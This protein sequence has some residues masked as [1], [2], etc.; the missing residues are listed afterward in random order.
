MYRGDRQNRRG[1]TLVEL[2][3][4]IAIIGMLVSLLLPAVQAA[5]EAARR[6]ECANNLKQIGLALQAYHDARRGF[7]PGWLWAPPADQSGG[8]SWAWS[9]FILP[10]LERNSLY[11][12]LRVDDG[13]ALVP[14]PGDP[15]DTLLPMFVCP[16]DVGPDR[17]KWFR[18]YAKSNYPGVNGTGG[19]T[20]CDGIPDGRVRA[21]FKDP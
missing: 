7:P 10:Y 13:S 14:P 6:T 3:I 21:A 16:S 8:S 5:R 19:D 2:L 11:D 20:D 4:V 17:N 9:V 15:R 1:F 18:G 12:E